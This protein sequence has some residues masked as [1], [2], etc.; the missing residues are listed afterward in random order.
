MPSRTKGNTLT[1]SADAGT[2]VVV[3][4]ETGKVC[5]NS[6]KFVSEDPNLTNIY[7]GNDAV[8]ELGSPES[9]VVTITAGLDGL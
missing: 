5:K 1:D 3:A 6:V 2:E 4:M 7:L 9:I 8:T